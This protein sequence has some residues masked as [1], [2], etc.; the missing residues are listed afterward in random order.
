MWMSKSC[1]EKRSST[2]C[3]EDGV[4]A[5]CM[6]CVTLSVV[7]VL[8]HSVLDSIPAHLLT[9]LLWLVEWVPSHLAVCHHKGITDF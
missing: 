1:A 5:D 7:T 2:L 4:I 6:G 9:L 3:E 8:L